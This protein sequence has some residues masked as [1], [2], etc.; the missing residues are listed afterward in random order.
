MSSKRPYMLLAPCTP[1]ENLK[2]NRDSMDKN[3]SSKRQRLLEAWAK[4]DDDLDATQ[5][6]TLLPDC[7]PSDDFLNPP[8]RTIMGDC[9]FLC[10]DNLNLNTTHRDTKDFFAVEFKS[11][12]LDSRGERKVVCAQCYLKHLNI[13]T[14][15]PHWEKDISRG[16]TCWVCGR[17][18]KDI[19]EDQPK[20]CCVNCTKGRSPSPRWFCQPCVENVQLYAV[21]MKKLLL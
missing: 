5:D 7:T 19:K 16:D 20:W 13:M 15:Q 10:L 21:A 8:K 18:R 6:L 2:D 14:R 1:E 11:S 4:D 17:G 9:C 12:R 3:A